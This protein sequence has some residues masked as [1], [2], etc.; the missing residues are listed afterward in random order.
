MSFEEWWKAE[1]NKPAIGVWLPSP[2]ESARM[3]WEAATARCG[4]EA[5]DLRN[6]ASCKKV[7]KT[8]S[9][10]IDRMRKEQP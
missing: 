3:A 10:L 6:N 8:C 7:K 9:A 4:A 1:C 2:K 5:D